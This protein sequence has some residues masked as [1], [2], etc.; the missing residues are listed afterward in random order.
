MLINLSVALPLIVTLIAA[1]G[2]F[3][4]FLFKTFAIKHEIHP[5]LEKLQSDISDLGGDVK[6]IR[7]VIELAKPILQGNE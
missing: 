4:G 3:M 5:K 6:A 7:E 2:G 1:I